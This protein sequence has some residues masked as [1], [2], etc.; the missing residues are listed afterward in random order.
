MA[1]GT[2]HQQAWEGVLGPGKNLKIQG[3]KRG[4]KEQGEAPGRLREEGQ[5]GGWG[6]F[7]GRGGVRWET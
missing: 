7:S 2:G 4:G 3:N 1:G 6:G 5:A